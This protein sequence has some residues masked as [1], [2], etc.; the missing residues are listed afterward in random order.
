MEVIPKSSSYH[1][2][3]FIVA[4]SIAKLV[5]FLYKVVCLKNDSC[6]DVDAARPPPLC[7]P[8]I[9]N[10]YREEEGNPVILRKNQLDLGQKMPLIL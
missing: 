10:P 4:V 7:S 1:V 3:Y 6:I 9:Y 2:P 5:A 8:L